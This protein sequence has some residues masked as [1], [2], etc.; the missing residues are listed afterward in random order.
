M[1]FPLLLTAAAIVSGPA[2]AATVFYRDTNLMP[3]QGYV[4]PLTTL[5]GSGVIEERFNSPKTNTTLC[6]LQHSFTFRYGIQKN[7]QLGTTFN[8]DQAQLGATAGSMFHRAL[9]PA[10]DDSCYIYGPQ[11]SNA[12][13]VHLEHYPIFVQPKAVVG[14][15]ITPTYFGMYL[16]SVDD[17]NFFTLG[18]DTSGDNSRPIII[19]GLGNQTTGTFTGAELA[20]FLGVS[21]F[22]S[23]YVEFFFTPADHF[24]YISVGTNNTSIELDNMATSYSA[25]T[26]PVA[27]I[28]AATPVATAQ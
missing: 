14:A 27:N 17:Y 16:G 10:G 5:P 25:V 8:L 9:A 3:G 15:T 24:S 7:Q 6:A 19:P 23:H 1:R 13:T 4:S 20:T 18:A 22:T 21:L 11:S 2:T 12:L 28:P 26:P